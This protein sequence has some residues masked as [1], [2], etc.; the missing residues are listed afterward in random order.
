MKYILI[1][2]LVIFQGLEAYCQ[3]SLEGFIKDDKKN[4]IPYAIVQLT[5]SNTTVRSDAKGKVVFKDLQEG[6]YTLYVNF[7]GYKP[8]TKKVVVS[9]NTNFLIVLQED[10]Q[11][12]DQVVVYGKTEATLLREEAYAVEVIETEGLKNS[13]VDASQLLGRI[14]GVNI[15]QD[16][17]LGSSF[18]LSLNGLSGNRIRTFI[19]GIPMDYFGTSL[20]LNNFP[21]NQIEGIEVYKGAVPIHLSSDALGGAVNVVTNHKPINYL[22][23]SYSYGSF[24]THRA[25]INAQ[26]HNEKSGFTTRIKSFLNHSDNDYE[27]DVNLLDFESGKLD[28]NTTKVKRFHD[29]YTSKM[30]WV[31]A[32]LMNK[33]YAD[34]LMFGVLVSDNFKEI[35]QN[36][37][38]TGTPAF[39]V[40][41]AFSKEE[42]LIYNFA[43]RKQDLF[44]KGLSLNSY[45]VFVDAVANNVDKSPN[46]YDW[47]GNYKA[48]AHPTTGE[49]GRKSDF[50]MDTEN[51][52]GNINGEY[53][54]A[55][56]HSVALNYSLNSLTV[57]GEDKYQPQNNTQ[58]SNP[59]TVDKHVWGASYTYSVFD[60]KW[61][62]IAFAKKYYYNLFAIQSNFQGTESSDFI[63]KNDALGY[64]IASTF[65]LKHFQFKTSYE[66]AYRFPESYELF[67]DGINVIPNQELLPE[68]SD[69]LNF[70]V[71]YQTLKANNYQ[72]EMNLFVRNTK[73]YIRFEPKMNRSFYVNDPKVISKGIDVTTSYVFSKKFTAS[74]AGTYL[75]LR[76]NDK[77]QIVYNDRLPNEPYLFGNM[78][79]VY[80]QVLP[81][82]QMLSVTGISRYVHEFYLLWPSLA[83]SESKS[84]IPSQLTFNIDLT[85]TFK[86][87]KYNLSLL[88]AN[89]LNAK[90]YDNLN[91]Q[92]PGRAFSIKARYF[93]QN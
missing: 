49:M 17:G 28:E 19:N 90:V 6:T 62:T 70:G 89:V 76:N 60:D 67:G 34:E 29:A 11:E 44:V 10:V 15:R 40:G 68:E 35:Q 54:F 22:D 21:V 43:Y 77:D 52:L 37:Y 24:K 69:N 3:N 64:G 48:D 55:N 73:N 86:E 1:F 79:L 30:T 61:S 84:I 75:D 38:A 85:Y 53:A 51:L 58:F 92:K 20:T 47:H 71:K 72:I 16:G 82:K 33:K 32:G 9:A 91:Q 66:K 80:N 87:G 31:E 88:C 74:L 65:K 23:A 27:I 78:T 8:V 59:N 13:T 45:V 2:C 56:H 12:L 41:E 26:Y 63:Y 18:D 4:P 81:K 83:A 50:T 14:S 46:R 93:I 42:K 36:P 57:K 7:L 5:E 39:P 25:S